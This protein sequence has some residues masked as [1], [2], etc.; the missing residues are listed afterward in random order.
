MLSIVPW[1]IANCNVCINPKKATLAEKHTI[2]N[3][4]IT[5]KPINEFDVLNSYMKGKYQ[6]FRLSNFGM[7]KTYSFRATSS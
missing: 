6:N 1:A 4:I 3:L 7:Y 5:I 2:L